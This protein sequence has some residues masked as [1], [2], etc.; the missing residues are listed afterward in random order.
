MLGLFLESTQR[1]KCGIMHIGKNNDAITSYL[2]KSLM[3]D[4]TKSLEQVNELI[5][6]GSITAEEILDYAHRLTDNLYLMDTAASYMSV[7]ESNQLF[8]NIIDNITVDVVLVD[9]DTEIDDDITQN[10]IKSSDLVLI[11]MEQAIDM[12]KRLKRWRESPYYDAIE[13]ATE[14][15]VI[16]RYNREVCAL[17]DFART[18]GISERHTE[19]VD[20]CTLIQKLSNEGKLTTLMNYVFN[21]QLRAFGIASDMKRLIQKIYMNL[22]LPFVD[23][24]Q[25]A[26]S[27]AEAKKAKAAEA[28]GVA[29]KRKR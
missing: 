17:K 10:V 13:M 14:L 20:Y 22:N 5:N 27:K 1:V 15:F 16:N 9:I 12:A 6:Q 4:K 25:A 23:W 19:K 24:D 7:K 8:M 11:V 29:K 2:G 26:K 3:E 18:A 21:H 28:K